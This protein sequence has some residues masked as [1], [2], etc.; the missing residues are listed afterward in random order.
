MIV[1][2]MYVPIYIS[3]FLD[4]AIFFKTVP[5][6]DKIADSQKTSARSSF[7]NNR[8]PIFFPY[9]SCKRSNIVVYCFSLTF[10]A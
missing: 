9:F 7:T 10:G 1:H 3:I 2:S 5:K 8:P 6:A 4:F